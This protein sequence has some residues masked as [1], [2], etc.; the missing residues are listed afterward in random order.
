MT[1]RALLW[2]VPLTI[3][4][5]ILGSLTVVWGVSFA[6]GFAMNASLVAALSGVL[7]AA[8]IARDLWGSS[9]I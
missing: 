2:Q 5:C 8:A 9:K 1:Y 7:S 4:A 3:L 6:F